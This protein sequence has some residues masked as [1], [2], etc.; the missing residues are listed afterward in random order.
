MPSAQPEGEGPS[1]VEVA[2]ARSYTA[3]LDAAVEEW[4]SKE[5]L[6]ASVEK[7]SRRS[8]SG[9]FAIQAIVKE[10]VREMNNKTAEKLGCTG[11]Y[12]DKI[13]VMTSMHQRYRQL[14]PAL[15]STFQHLQLV[16]AKFGVRLKEEVTRIR[17]M[18]WAAA[19]PSIPL[20]EYKADPN[21]WH[22]NEQFPGL[23]AVHR[24]PWVFVC[25]NVFSKKA[26]EALIAKAKPCLVPSWVYRGDRTSW[27]VRIEHEEVSGLQARLSD[28]LDMPLSR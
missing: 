4:Q 26:C 15:D 25:K 27:E 23:Q 13:A 5:L 19:Y 18:E 16:I 21:F 9:G 11:A 10:L 1:S 20:S 2:C 7:L 8:S 24:D 22:I 6:D 28:L 17:D 12:D 14:D 3:I